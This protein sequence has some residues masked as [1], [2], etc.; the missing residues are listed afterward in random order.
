[1]HTLRWT[2]TNTAVKM[3]FRTE[4]TRVYMY[5]SSGDKQLDLSLA[6]RYCR[7]NDSQGKVSPPKTLDTEAAGQGLNE[8]GLQWSPTRQPVRQPCVPFKPGNRILSLIEIFLFL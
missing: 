4:F 7:I 6:K 1:M 2:L 5:N 3:S 8:S